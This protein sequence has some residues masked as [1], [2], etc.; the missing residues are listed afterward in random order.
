MD[1]NSL[2]PFENAK[3]R[4]IGQDQACIDVL[5]HDR[6]PTLTALSG[7]RIASR[8]ALSPLRRRHRRRYGH[9]EARALSK[10]ASVA[11]RGSQCIARPIVMKSNE[12]FPASKSSTAFQEPNIRHRPLRQMRAKASMAGSMSMAMQFRRTARIRLPSFPDRS[13]H[14][15]CG[16]CAFN[17]RDVETARRIQEDTARDTDRTP[18]WFQIFP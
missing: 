5:D 17:P 1:R 7:I 13:L 6:V 14:R 11:L 18:P 4:T 8:L 15:A 16:L 10:T 3:G 2:H 12:L 9:H